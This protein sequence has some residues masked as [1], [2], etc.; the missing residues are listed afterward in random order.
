MAFILQK[1]KQP[2]FGTNRWVAVLKLLGTG[3]CTSVVY[4]NY[5]ENTTLVA[6]CFIFALLDLVYIYMVFKGPKHSATE[7]QTA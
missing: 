4:Y 7:V 2:E 1:V 5:Y 3:L 6:L